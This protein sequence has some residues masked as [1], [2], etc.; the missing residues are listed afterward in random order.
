MI[1]DLNELLGWDLPESDDY[2]TVAGFVLS[3]VGSIPETG[4]RL[5]L[6][7]AEIEIL[8]ASNRKIDSMRIQRQNVTDQKVG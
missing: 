2:E 8:K 3:H 1:D 6:G 4:T 7:D 5:T